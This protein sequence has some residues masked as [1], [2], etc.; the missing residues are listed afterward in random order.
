MNE[1]RVLVALAVALAVALG[2]A[3]LA[4]KLGGTPGSDEQTSS[5]PSRQEGRPRAEPTEPHRPAPAAP[6]APALSP[7]ARPPARTAHLEGRDFEA[8]ITTRGATLSSF[9]LRGR[10]YRRTIDGRTAQ[11]DLVSTEREK[12]LPLRLG[13]RSADFPFPRQ[14]IDYELVSSDAR[15]AVFEYRNA[16]V[17][18]RRRYEVRDPF[19]L[20]L[21]TEVQ[22]LT[23]AD[24]S[25]KLELETFRFVGR[26]DEKGRLFSQPPW[27]V[28]GVCEIGGEIKRHARSDL[29]QEQ[30]S[31]GRIGFASADDLYFAQVLLPQGAA[32]AECRAKARV[33]Y[34][35]D[36]DEPAGTLYRVSLAYETREV[37]PG[38]TASYVTRAYFGPKDRDILGQID[39][40]LQ[41][42]V[43]FGWLEPLC[44]ILL[45]VLQFFQTLVGNWGLAIILLTVSVKILLF[46]LSQKSFKSMR[47]M[48]RVKPLID[49]VNERYANDKDRRNQ[50]LMALYKEHKI[51]PFSGCLPIL[52]QM[53]IGFALYTTLWRAID[54]Y[55]EPF[56][57]YWKDLSAPD[58]YFVL[59]L[60]LG[61]TMFIQQRMTPTTMDPA[62]QKMMQYFMPIMFTSF[63]LFLPVGLTIY[64]LTNTLLTITQ[65]QLL[66]RRMPLPATAAAPARSSAPSAPPPSE[67]SRAP[68]RPARRRG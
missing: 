41:R 65:Q 17:L 42:V 52:F 43:D 46:P 18:L 2:Y 44:K 64:I 15:H 34:E 39:P 68:Q 16:K 63:M 59:P 19:Q 13:F 9:R 12:W 32:K 26:H 3:F 1:K 54:L 40:K 37:A 23:N 10:K 49:Q 53:P 45:H 5:A 21:T 27:N 66:Y 25:H 28:S 33:L 8:A 35:E 4:P 30:T 31:A 24:Q 20:V 57:L 62:Q 51:N 11:V 38:Q 58:P 67:V 55:Q 47:E 29:W 36:S 7:A 14:A 50:A 48:Q 56:V 61:G 60:V 22:N 6:P